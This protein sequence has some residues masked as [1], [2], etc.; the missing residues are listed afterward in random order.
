MAPLLPPLLLLALPLHVS[1]TAGGGA[2][3]KKDLAAAQP[4]RSFPDSAGKISLLVDQ[5]PG[6]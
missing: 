1:A 6:E 5:L 4:A 3:Q 2:L